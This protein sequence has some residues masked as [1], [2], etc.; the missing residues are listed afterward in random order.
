[1][2]RVVVLA[3]VSVLMTGIV[4]VDQVY[5]GAQRRWGRERQPRAGVCFFADT[6]FN[7]D[8]FCVSPG[9]DVPELPRGMNDEISSFRIIGDVDLVVFRD[10]N[11]RGPSARFLNDIADLR[12]ERWNDEISSLRVSNVSSAVR[13]RDRDQDRDR[14]PVWS[15]QAARPQEGACFYRDV[16]FGGEYFCVPR[17]ASYARVPPGFNDR[18][19][20]I[21][22]IRA[23]GVI[24]FGDFDFGGRSA[25]VTADVA[26]LRRGVWN[27]RVSSIRVF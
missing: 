10:V 4:G 27:D 6:N 5:G 21:R 24:V 1:M 2:K 14:F 16:N 25:R 11:F 12:R 9:D 15:R 7:G 17:G 22:I 8:Y 18:I 3:V 23:G 20:S 19:S 26:D 13:G